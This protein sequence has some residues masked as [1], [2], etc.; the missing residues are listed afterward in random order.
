MAP[1]SRDATVRATAARMPYQPMPSGPKSSHRQRD[2]VGR[3]VQR[4]RSP[5]WTRVRRLRHYSYLWLWEFTHALTGSFVEWNL[6]SALAAA[7]LVDETFDTACT[8]PPRQQL[9]GSD[10][11]TSDMTSR[12]RLNAFMFFMRMALLPST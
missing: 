6:D 9:P 7:R 5:P 8:P 11:G 10:S 4:R 3:H 2:E 1:A 12:I